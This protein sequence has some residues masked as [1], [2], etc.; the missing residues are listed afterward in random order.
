MP[1]RAHPRQIGLNLR[2]LGP[3][4]AHGTS[5][6]L[7]GDGRGCA[8]DLG[9]DRGQRAL[10]GGNIGVQPAHLGPVLL[11]LLDQRNAALRQFGMLGLEGQAT[12]FGGLQFALTVHQLLVQKV[13]RLLHVALIV[14]VAAIAEDLD[15]LLDDIA[16]EA[17]AFRIG[18]MARTGLCG[19][20]KDV[21]LGGHDLDRLARPPMAP[22]I[23]LRSA[24]SSPSRVPRTTFS[25]LAALVSVSRTRSMSRLRSASPM[26]TCAESGS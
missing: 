15:H 26:P 24:M 21:V 5:D 18:H 22:S 23:C 19:H 14:A 8:G 11:K 9:V 4:A 13:Q 7:S 3:R 2:Q 10:R 25:R 16:R 17:G 1:P 12:L 6:G 20:F